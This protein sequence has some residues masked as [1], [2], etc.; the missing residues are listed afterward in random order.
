MNLYQLTLQN[1][2]QLAL[3]DFKV[4]YMQHCTCDN[5]PFFDNFVG[6]IITKQQGTFSAARKLENY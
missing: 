3:W 2:I 6:L 4:R 5:H 1:V